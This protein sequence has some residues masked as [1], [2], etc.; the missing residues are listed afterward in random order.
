MVQR[1]KGFTLIELVVVITILGILAAT[2]LPRF[3]NTTGDAHEAAVAGTGGGFATG[4]MLSHAQWLVDGSASG[5]S[6]ISMD[7]QDVGMFAGWP[8]T[9][10]AAGISAIT[11]AQCVQVWLSVMLNPPS[12]NTAVG[13]DYLVTLTADDNGDDT[14]CT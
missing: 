1:N 8:R 2:A 10:G 13:S 12:A 11:D 9:D 14:V 7:G 4:V 6:V 5:G 3:I